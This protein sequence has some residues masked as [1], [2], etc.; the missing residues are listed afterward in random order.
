M[1]LKFNLIGW[2]IEWRQSNMWQMWTNVVL[3]LGQRLRRW[4]NIKPALVE[5]LVFA[6][7][8]Y[9]VLFLFPLLSYFAYTVYFV[10]LGYTHIRTVKS[11]SATL[12]LCLLITTIVVFN[13]LY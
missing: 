11:L 13:L 8:C 2:I 12:T 10:I 7:V 6:G 1:N 3:L 5:G 4:P 9:G